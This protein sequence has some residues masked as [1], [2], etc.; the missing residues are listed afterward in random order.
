MT[1]V[2][3]WGVKRFA[4]ATAIIERLKAL[5]LWAMVNSM[6]N[7]GGLPEMMSASVD[8]DGVML[9]TFRL[10]DG[11]GLTVRATNDGNLRTEEV[12][13]YV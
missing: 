12:P 6:L 13:H 8:D 7:R 2:H 9:L 5:K 1:G 3:I 10:G 4:L 11:S